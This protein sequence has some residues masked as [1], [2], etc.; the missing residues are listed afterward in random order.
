ML[1]FDADDFEPEDFPK[2]TTYDDLVRLASPRRSGYQ[3]PSGSGCSS[4]AEC[5][6][7]TRIFGEEH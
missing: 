1:R 7:L 5:D 4:K 3:C 6:R 2:G